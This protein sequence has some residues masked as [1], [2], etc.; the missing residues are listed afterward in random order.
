MSVLKLPVSTGFIHNAVKKY[1]GKLDAAIDSIRTT[2]Y[3]A[4]VVHA[5]ET[6][7]RAAGGTTWLHNVSDE[8]YTYQHVSEKCG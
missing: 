8:M 2:L 1:A 3:S 4:P 6:G 5:D 7:V